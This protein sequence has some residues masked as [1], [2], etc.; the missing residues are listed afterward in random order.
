M[1]LR[2]CRW[3]RKAGLTLCRR[4]AAAYPAAP[5][6]LAN[7]GLGLRLCGLYE[8][9]AEAYARAA[10]ASSR[11]AWVLNDWALLESAR[12]R[13]LSAMRLLEEGARKDGDPAGRDTCRTNL[14][15]L[16]LKR[17]RPGDRERAG[18]LLDKVVARD[19]G[20]IRAWFW[21]NRL[22]RELPGGRHVEPRAQSG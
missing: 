14:A 19:P 22:R 7:L 3:G 20:R 13:V 5:W 6:A 21:W 8:E 12:G 1:A 11:A 17:G 16:L 15:V 9:A 18:L 10:A 2:L 4:L